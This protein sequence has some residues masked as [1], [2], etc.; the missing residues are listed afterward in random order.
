MFRRVRVTVLLATL[1]VGCVHVSVYQPFKD[2]N[3]MLVEAGSGKSMI[4]SAKAILIVYRRTPEVGERGSEAKEPKLEIVDYDDLRTVRFVD[5]QVSFRSSAR[6]SV[7]GHEAILVYK[8]GYEP[9]W[10]ERRLSGR[11]YR[12]PPALT[13]RRCDP[14]RSKQMVCDAVRQAFR[15]ESESTRQGALK[16]LARILQ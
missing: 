14:V 6:G 8:T 13:L 10:L 3:T 16:K 1:L 9:V 11:E 4:S 2:V 12:Y 7:R 15:L 5:E